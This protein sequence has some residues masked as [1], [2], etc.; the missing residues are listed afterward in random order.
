MHFP[1]GLFAGVS[2]AGLGVDVEAEVFHF[3]IFL[4]AI[5]GAFAA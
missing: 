3:E 4:D 2:A 1:L 5:F